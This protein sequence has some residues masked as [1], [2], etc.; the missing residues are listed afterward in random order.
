[1]P[2]LNQV[3]TAKALA[4]MHVRVSGKVTRVRK[5]EKNIYTTVITPAKDEYSKPSIIE[6]RSVNRF[7]E[8]DDKVNFVGHLGGYEG[9]AYSITDRETGEKKNLVPVNLFLDFVE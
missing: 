4:P 5:Y 7:G 6:V 9:K 2:E 1:M 8:T 3:S